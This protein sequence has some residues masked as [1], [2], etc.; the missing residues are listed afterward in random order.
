[1]ELSLA[2]D[3]LAAERDSTKALA[4]LRSPAGRRRDSS[5]VGNPHR[6][7]LRHKDGSLTVAYEVEMPA[8]M[9]ADDSLVDIRYDD[10][11]RTLAFD[12]P[13]G[14]LIQFRYGTIP[15]PGYAII[16][17]ISGAPSKARICSR[18]SYK[19]RISTISV[20][21]PTRFP[22]DAVSFQCGSA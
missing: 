2:Y 10:P 18:R 19:L 17:L 12:K 11:A 8:T 6:D 1:M 13:A 22:I 21:L 5:I 9:F 14:T 16:N 7:A 4:T 3:E 20:T 15:D